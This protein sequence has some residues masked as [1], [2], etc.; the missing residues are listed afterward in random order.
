MPDDLVG[1]SLVQAEAERGLVLP[2]LAGDVV[3]S[4]QLVGET[5]AVR[6]QDQTADASQGLGGQKLDLG[7]GVVGLHQAGRV[8]LHPLQVDGLSANGLAHLDAVTGA[9]LSVGGGE[10]HQVGSVLSQEGVLSEVGTE[11]AAGQDHGAELLLVLAAFL[12]DEAD[13]GLA[14]HQEGV[15]TS[16]GDD[17]SSVGL[18]GNLL[19][20]LDECVGDGHARESLRTTV[21]SGSRVTTQSCQQGEIQ[22]E[23]LHQPVDVVAAVATEDL[24]NLGLLSSALQSVVGEEFDTVLNALG[25]L[26][27]GGRSVDTTSGFGGISTAERRLVEQNYLGT[28]LEQ[29]VGCRDTCETS[30]NNNS[31]VRREYSC[32]LSSCL[33][34]WISNLF[35][36]Q[37]KSH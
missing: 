13:A 2:H 29:G 5:L 23:L 37:Q 19:E 26:G 32:H 9:V 17:A 10:V 4:T 22:V 34:L 12:V 14:V 30:S 35:D 31:L 3:T 33:S 16:L 6:V 27:L 36:P 8:D 25:L 20:H 11:A 7:I 18:L 21:G 24:D 28:I 15:G 1:G